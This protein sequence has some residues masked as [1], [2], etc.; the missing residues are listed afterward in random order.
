MVVLGKIF[1][2]RFLFAKNNGERL[3]KY[4]DFGYNIKGFVPCQDIIDEQ[5]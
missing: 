2:N 4:T 1:T 3:E 5:N